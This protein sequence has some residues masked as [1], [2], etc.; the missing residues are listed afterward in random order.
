VEETIKNIVNQFFKEKKLDKIQETEKKL[1]K[2]FGEKFIKKNVE[3]ITLKEEKIIIKTKTIEA[4]TEINLY[5]K[6][7]TTTNKIIIK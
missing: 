5:K 3:N 4:K 6:T 1:L 2:Q 7:L